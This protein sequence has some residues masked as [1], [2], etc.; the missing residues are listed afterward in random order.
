MNC[1]DKKV[2]LSSLF[3]VIPDCLSSCGQAGA[4]DRASLV[5]SHLL[6]GLG[7]RHLKLVVGASA[8]GT[9]VGK[10]CPYINA[11]RYEEIS[12]WWFFW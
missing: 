7:L 3:S 6:L 1:M 12:H 10:N 4:E 9:P 5:P 8:Y 2:I 11:R